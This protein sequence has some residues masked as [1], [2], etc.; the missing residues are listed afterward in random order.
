[1]PATAGWGQIGPLTI[2]GPDFREIGMT[3]ET[4]DE[5]SVGTTV[6]PEAPPS[7]VR[8]PS[9]RRVDVI[10]A[11]TVVLAAAGLVGTVVLLRSMSAAPMVSS[12]PPARDDWYL[13]TPTALT[14]QSDALARPTVVSV[15]PAR[16][17]WYLDTPTTLTGQSGTSA[18][19][20]VSLPPNRDDWWLDNG[21]DRLLVQ[22]P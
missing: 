9:P 4:Q 13:T 11:S 16:D 17:D 6:A 10:G 15:P 8:K 3:I 20:M 21:G 19:P 22:Q 7:V 5:A 18:Q 12:V 14:A 1:V 2:S